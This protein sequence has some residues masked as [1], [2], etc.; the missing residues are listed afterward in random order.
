MRERLITPAAPPITAAEVMAALRIDS[1]HEEATIT[2][3]IAAA[4]ARVER[5]T[6]MAFGEQT[7]EALFGAFPD[8]DFVLGRVPVT[9]VVSI[10]YLD[11]DGVSQLADTDLY[12]IADA[13]REGRVLKLSAWPTAKDTANAV[14]VRYKA[15]TDWPEDVKQAIHLIVGHWFMYREGAAE[16]APSEIPY[17]ATELLR[18]HWRPFV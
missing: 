3:L 2:R 14:I 6:G 10:T 15:G 12:E 9:E 16:R 1:D 17:G 13:S 7:W 11:A 5:E 4:T 18:L 8:G